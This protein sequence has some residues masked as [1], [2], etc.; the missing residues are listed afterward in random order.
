MHLPEPWGS[1]FADAVIEPHPDHRPWGDF[2]EE[3]DEWGAV[4]T[5][6]G[7]CSLGEVSDPPLKDWAD[8][9]ALHVPDITEER[10]WEGVK[11]A[12]ERA[13]QRYLVAPGISLYERIHFIRGLENTWMDIYTNPDE[14]GRLIDLLA[15]MD[16]YAVRRFAECDVDAV[17][18]PDDWGLQDRLMIDPARWRELWLPRY[19]R[20]WQAAREVG[21]QTMLHSCG[22]IVEILDDMIDAGLQVIQ[23]D[24]QEN[25]GLEL[26]GARFGGRITFYSPVDIQGTMARGD[27]AEIRA[28]AQQMVRHLARPEGGFIPKTY[29][30]ARGAGHTKE[31]IHAMCDEFAALGADFPASAAHLWQG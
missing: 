20:V 16:V 18:W 3:R 9:E 1:D 15:E 28:Y 21:V 6:L 31:G 8:F 29:G 24:Q 11:T 2:T 27:P 14:L 30:D 4:W 10:R 22:Y 7:V 19:E 5:N 17:L 23:M 25:M 13:G 12:R 26:L